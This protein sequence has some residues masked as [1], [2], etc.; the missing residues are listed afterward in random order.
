MRET[1]RH[2]IVQISLRKEISECFSGLRLTVN[3]TDEELQDIEEDDILCIVRSMTC[4][5]N[6]EAD[7]LLSPMHIPPCKK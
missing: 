7:L 6:I 4:T 3:T 1:L 5:K 2:T